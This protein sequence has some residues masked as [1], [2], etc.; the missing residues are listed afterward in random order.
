MRALVSKFWA[1]ATDS[2]GKIADKP[3]ARRGPD[4]ISQRQ[5][6]VLIREK[7]RWSPAMGRKPNHRL[8]REMG[9]KLFRGLSMKNHIKSALCLTSL[10][11]FGL[12]L[13]G[14]SDT[15]F[16]ETR[17]SSANSGDAQGVKPQGTDGGEIDGPDGPDA[18]DPDGQ[19]QTDNPVG[20]DD[21]DGL[22]AVD[23]GDPEDVENKPPLTETEIK[24]RCVSGETATRKLTVS[25]P[26]PGRQCDWDQNGNMGLIQ[27]V[28]TARHEAH[29]DMGV[30]VDEVICGMRFNFSQQQM[31]YD[32]EI[33]LLFNGR[34]LMH[35]VEADMR[36]FEKQDGFY[37]FDWS[38]FVGQPYNANYSRINDYCIGSEDGKGSCSMP[39]TETNGTI[40]L[41]FDN[42][43]TYKLGAIA[44]K[45]RKGVFSWVTTG[46]NDAATDCQHMDI[47]FEVELTTAKK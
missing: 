26:N 11:V 38:R 44:D 23:T 24:E 34:F 1:A 20:L 19:D 43:V 3:Q 14:C 16:V 29:S 45:E 40:R 9:Q 2:G 18:G 39:P 13:L 42:D 37:V 46:D 6:S 35:S 30:G 41:E 31:R 22:D 47:N 15:S 10:L 33:S 7:A 5:L 21:G 12:R 27:G 28:V 17:D 25:F 32:D 4:R 8:T 36:F